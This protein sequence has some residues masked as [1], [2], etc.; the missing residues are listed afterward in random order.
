MGQKDVDQ[1]MLFFYIWR[2]IFR[3]ATEAQMVQMFT[4]FGASEGRPV[5]TALNI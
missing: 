5:R 2:H 3:E 1:F 4:R